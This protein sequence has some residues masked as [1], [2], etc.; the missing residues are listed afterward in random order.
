MQLTVALTASTATFCYEVHS[1]AMH[2]P[3]Y[4]PDHRLSDWPE[5]SLEVHR[6]CSE[7]VALLPIRH[8]IEQRGDR[9]ISAVLASLRCS[10]CN[11]MPGPVHLVAGQSRTF[12]H[13]PPPVWTLEL[14]P[15]PPTPART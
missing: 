5:C 12:N 6:P 14:I 2:P 13:G 10:S 7:R 4:H 9:T 1:T 3:A 8:L 11:G 15:P